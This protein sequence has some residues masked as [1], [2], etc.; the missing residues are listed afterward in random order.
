[1]AD[2]INHHLT[3]AVI[4]L[5]ED[6]VVSDAEAVGL[7]APELLTGSRPRLSLKRKDSANDTGVG[8]QAQIR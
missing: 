1:M 4:N 2:G 8:P 3:L 6:P 7:L 5:I